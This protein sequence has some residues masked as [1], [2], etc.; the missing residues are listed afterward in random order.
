MKLLR[1]STALLCLLPTVSALAASE[2]D[3]L[4]MPD[5]NLPI[6]A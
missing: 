6:P 1:L 3:C 2:A 4:R 5:A